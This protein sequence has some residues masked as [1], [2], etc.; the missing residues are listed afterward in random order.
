[1][2]T[3]ITTY[4]DVQTGTR[5]WASSASSTLA[6]EG[7]AE[8]AKPA[9][10]II[11]QTAEGVADRVGL[12]AAHIAVMRGAQ[13]PPKQRVS[14]ASIHA[15]AKA[16]PT[17]CIGYCDAQYLLSGI[18]PAGYVAGALG[19]DCDIY[20]I[21]GLTIVTGYRPAAG[22]RGDDISA[23]TH[24]ADELARLYPDDRDHITA[25]WIA[26][27]LRICAGRDAGRARA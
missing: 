10:S 18:K 22:I 27:L 9:A 21:A 5:A 13:Q 19:W 17:V 12:I 6:A 25:A 24:D 23:V 16:L 15:E 26:N 2:P 11:Q 4:D 20:R 1:M 14:R 3:F 7:A 8:D